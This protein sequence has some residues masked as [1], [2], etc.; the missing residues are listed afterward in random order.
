MN[1]AYTEPKNNIS[2]VTYEDWGMFAV[3]CCGEWNDI[4]LEHQTQ[5]S[6]GGVKMLYYE[7]GEG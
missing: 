1:W 7:V 3:H 5:V 4:G 2:G 6:W